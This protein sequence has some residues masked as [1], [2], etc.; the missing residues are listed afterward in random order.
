MRPT[1]GLGGRKNEGTRRLRNVAV[2]QDLTTMKRYVMLVS[3]ALA[4]AAPVM[5]WAQSQ[6][7]ATRRAH[8]IVA[9]INA[10]TPSAIRAYVDT[11]M[12]A[13]MRRL[14]MQ[15]HL[16]FMLGQRELSRGLDWVEIQEEAPSRTTALLKRR[17]TGDLMAV[18][19]QV[20]DT[21]PYQINGIGP[22]PPHPKAAAV[23]PRLTSDAEMVSALERY[24]KALAQADVFSGTVLLAK[25]GKTLYSAAFGQANK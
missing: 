8:E 5:G 1:D 16:D 7:P 17:L 10:A 22:R 6:P 20:E 23:E 24:V 3:G 25:N 2:H 21:A 4:A 11:A 14:P 13:G 15:A 9:L 19:V 18:Q 12:A